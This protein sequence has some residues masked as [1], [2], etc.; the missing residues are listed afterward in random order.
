MDSFCDN[1]IITIFQFVGLDDRFRF[2]M[3]GKKYYKV[4]SDHITTPEWIYDQINQFIKKNVVVDFSLKCCVLPNEYCEY[5]RRHGGDKQDCDVDNFFVQQLNIGAMRCQYK[6]GKNKSTICRGCN[7]CEWLPNISNMTDDLTCTWEM[8]SVQNAPPNY[9]SVSEQDYAGRAFANMEKQPGINYC[10]YWSASRN[11]ASNIIIVDEY[12][13]EEY[14]HDHCG[15][16][17]DSLIPIHS[18]YESVGI[19]VHNMTGI[20]Q[21]HRNLFDYDIAHLQLFHIVN[22]LASG[23]I[24]NASDDSGSEQNI[25]TLRFFLF[26]ERVLQDCI[27]KNV[28]LLMKT[29]RTGS[30]KYI[31]MIHPEIELKAAEVAKH[32]MLFGVG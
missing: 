11:H 20:E 3:L 1:L 15:C 22:F 32:I 6:N 14:T 24:S 2:I 16:T 7:S 4:V 21:I 30:P 13:Y 23:K 29:N 31:F 17:N 27:H 25:N 18:V 10:A 26:V 9:A 19:I 5:A 28:D 12:E 8:N